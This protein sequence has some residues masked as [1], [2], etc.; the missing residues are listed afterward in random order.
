MKRS[1]LI[2]AMFFLTFL[3]PAQSYDQEVDFGIRMGYGITNYSEIKRSDIP[4]GYDLRNYG[5]GA[6]A[7][8]QLRVNHFYFQPELLYMHVSTVIAAPLS[9][10]NPVNAELTMNFNSVQNS[11]DHWMEK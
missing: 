8:L 2:L 1:V 3:L 4:D 5:Y 6:G 11:A 10:Q 9:Q 7:F